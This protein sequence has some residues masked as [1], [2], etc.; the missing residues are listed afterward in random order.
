MPIHPAF[1]N[2]LITLSKSDT[3][4]VTTVTTKTHTAVFRERLSNKTVRDNAVRY[5]G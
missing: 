4:D 1:D 3:K 2:I 5:Y